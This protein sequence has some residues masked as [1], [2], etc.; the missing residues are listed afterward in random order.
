[1]VRKLTVRAGSGC[2]SS[3]GELRRQWRIGG[4]VER[5]ELGRD[6]RLDIVHGH[7]LRHGDLDVG[8]RLHDRQQLDD[9]ELELQRGE[10]QRRPDDRYRFLDRHHRHER[11]GHFFQYDGEWLGHD[12]HGFRNRWSEHG[13][14]RDWH[15]GDW[16]GDD[17]NGNDQ[18]R[19][20]WLER[21]Q[22]DYR[23]RRS[24]RGMRPI[25]LRE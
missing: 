14:H 25:R 18:C 1:M 2:L 22:W 6:D 4:D 9:G 17:W 16:N 21:K 10:Q 20:D 24:R 7:E 23:G 8:K 5:D 19:D 15:R 11:D 13:H 3:S 12:E